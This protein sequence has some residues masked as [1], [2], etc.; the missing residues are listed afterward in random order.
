MRMVSGKVSVIVPCYNEATTIRG[1][2]EGLLEQTYGLEDFD[3]AIADGGSTDGTLDAIDGFTRE[4][5]ELRV[6]IVHNPDRTIPSGIN[7]AIAATDGSTIVRL[8]AH[9][10]PEKDYIEQCMK[11][12]ESSRAANAG[13]AWEI[14]P[15]GEGWISRSIAAAGASFLGAGDAKYR[16]GG[17]AGPV[18]TVPF[19]T[20][21]RE[22]LDKVG[23]F[24]ET[25]LTNEDYEYNYRIRQAGGIVW[26]DPRIRSA[27]FARGNLG[28]L[29]R[30]YARYGYW[31][32][33]MLLKHPGS[34]R[35]RQLIPGGFVFAVLFLVVIS[36]F[37]AAAGLFLAT[38]LGIY[39]AVVLAAG[40]ISAARAQDAG[41]LVG[42]P[43]AIA[44]MHFAWGSAFL[45]GLLTGALEKIIG[46]S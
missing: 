42:F 16:T 1:L 33:R 18:D 29:L 43:L 40:A 12:L 24:D 31:K 37:T 45:W 22:W 8:D 39:S 4:H 28:T 10:F 13:G 27:Y 35:M 32:S 3:V 7:K 34:L 11:A 30:Q 25:L 38:V 44:V 5:P 6:R 36:P 2:L 9:S 14:R 21:P 17:K 19:G 20:Y 46:Q 26:F 15:S 41:M 23:P